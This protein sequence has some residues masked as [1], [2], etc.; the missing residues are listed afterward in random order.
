MAGQIVGD[1]VQVAEGRGL[2]EGVQEREIA[3]GVA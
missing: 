1:K 3:S 2:V